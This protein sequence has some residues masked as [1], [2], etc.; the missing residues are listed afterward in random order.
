MLKFKIVSLVLLISSSVLGENSVNPNEVDQYIGNWEG[1][2][3]FY[4]VNF[5]ED[6]G[7]L[8]IHLEVN[9]DEKISGRVGNASLINGEISVDEHNH[10]FM[11]RGQLEGK[12]F[13]DSDFHKKKIILLLQIPQ[14][15]KIEGDFHLKNNFVFDFSMRPGGFTLHRIP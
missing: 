6:V 10:G 14:G 12:I 9:P 13:P 4:N 2:G 1:Q 11:I 8:P 3:R 15:D 7:M 5:H